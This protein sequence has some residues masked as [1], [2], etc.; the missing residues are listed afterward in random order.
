VRNITVVFERTIWWDEPSTVA[1][2][3]QTRLPHEQ[4]VARWRDVDDAATGIRTM[5]VRGAP[6]IGVAAAHGLALAMLD[7]PHSLD[8]AVERLA[9]TRPTAVNLRWALER[10]RVALEPL[11]AA[12]RAAVARRLASESADEDAAAC[13]AIGEAGVGL[14][15]GLHGRTGRPVQVLTHCNAGRLACV[16]WGTATA[17]VYVAHQRDIPVHVWVSE[18]RPR[19]QGAALTTWELRDRG[20]PHTLVV[21]NAAG[22]LLRTGLVDVVIVGA[23]RIAANGDVANK[24]GTALKALAAADAGVPFLVAAPRST[25]DPRCPDG[26]AI[27]IEERD[28]RE[29]LVVNDRPIAPAGTRARNWGFDVTPAR[30]VDHYVTDHGLLRSDDLAG[31][32]DG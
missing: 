19:N 17:P 32:L 2:V 16:E 10:M 15:A 3:D 1:V 28:E 5:Q 29:V 30:L 22:H 6:L 27:P 25:F 24:I 23:D 4:A 14:L 7:D 21:D 20:V 18:T 9:A 26:D 8:T 12:D 31:F 11:P 13:R